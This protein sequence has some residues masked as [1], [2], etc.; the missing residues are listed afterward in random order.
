MGLLASFALRHLG[1]IL[2]VAAVLASLGSVYAWHRVQVRQAYDQGVSVTDA[3]WQ[4][5]EAAQRYVRDQERRAT[6]ADLDQI[7]GDYREVERQL[8]EERAQRNA[9]EDRLV[10]EGAGG[11]IVIPDAFLEPLREIGR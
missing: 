11:E 6:Q 3:K 8:T 5:Q 4:Q 7:A 9:A 1:S 10:R 2:V